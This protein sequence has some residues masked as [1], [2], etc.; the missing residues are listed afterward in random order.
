MWSFLKKPNS[1]A[2]P[3]ET[4]RAEF[5]I[6]LKEDNSILNPSILLTVSS[7]PRRYNYAYI[8]D[9]G[10]YYFVTDWISE[11]NLWRAELACDVLASFKN[12]ILASQCYV[13]RSASQYN[14]D[15]TDTMY[16]TS[17][18]INSAAYSATVYSW[19]P[20]ENGGSYVIGTISKSGGAGGCI[21]YYLCTPAQMKALVSFML[22]SSTDYLGVQTDISDNLWK[23]LFNPTSYIV[24]CVYYPFTAQASG[25]PTNIQFGWW[26]STS[27]GTPISEKDY[28]TSSW[29]FTIPKHPQISRGNYL[30]GAPYSYFSIEHPLIGSIPINPADIYGRNSVGILWNIDAP[31]GMGTGYIQAR[32]GDAIYPCGTVQQQ[33]GVQ[34][35]LSSITGSMQAAGLNTISGWIQNSSIGKGI[36]DFLGIQPLTDAISGLNAKR[37][38]VDTARGVGT[39]AGL[40][41]A[42]SSVVPGIGS[43]T[44]SL[45]PSVSS[46]GSQGQFSYF[47]T[48]PQLIYKYYTLAPEDNAHYGRPLCEKVQLNALTGFTKTA[49][50]DVMTLGTSAE[51]TA[52]N[53]LLDSGVY[54]E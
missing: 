48:K 37:G 42:V 3:P 1:T 28:I 13:L 18:K 34:I 36:A 46:T 6:T 26:T 23:T 45:A 14:T 50:A 8:P 49:N 35:Q 10:R 52:I 41:S 9:F 33:I 20:P 44:E 17:A 29:A 54:L 11:R 32:D 16:P 31:S 7:N 53:Q 27:T 2:Q 47:F 22:G 43:F 19:I 51:N 21:Q 15:I 24:S 39:A 5:D 40:V 30:M 4:G 25:S 38:D 12:E